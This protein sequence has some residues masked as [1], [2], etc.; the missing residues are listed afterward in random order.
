MRVFM[1]NAFDVRG[2]LMTNKVSQPSAVGNRPH[3]KPKTEDPYYVPG[4]SHP[5][6]GVSLR[7]SALARRTQTPGTRDR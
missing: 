6:N 2:F 1:V 4:L 5:L 7:V 3:V